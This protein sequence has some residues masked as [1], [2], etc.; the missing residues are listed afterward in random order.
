MRVGIVGVGAMGMGICRALLDRGLTV[1]VRDLVAAKEDEARSHGAFV[2][3]SPAGLASQVDV[4]LTVV[5]DAG[6]G[7]TA[8]A[9][10]Q[11]AALDCGCR[12]ARRS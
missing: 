5:V 3:A 8:S 7:L 11:P 9:M 6:R 2:A 10:G 1:G 4:L 12:L